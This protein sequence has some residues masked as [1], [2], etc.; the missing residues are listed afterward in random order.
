MVAHLVHA[1]ADGQLAVVAVLLKKGSSNS[2]VE[3]VWTNIPKEKDKAVDVSS[4]SLNV[5]DI[6]PAEHSYFTFAGS[7]T[8]PP[9]RKE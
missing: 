9:A 5:K 8:T 7:L 4:V 6:L 1:D 2:F 3:T